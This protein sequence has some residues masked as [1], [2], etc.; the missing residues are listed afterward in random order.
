M[1]ASP[2]LLALT[3]ALALAI[4]VRAQPARPAPSTTASAAPQ[5]PGD[6]LFAQADFAAA[7][8]AYARAL[9]ANSA[10]VPAHVGLARIA[11][12]HNDLDV[13]ETHARAIV[14]AD[15]A[16][17]RGP[18]LLAAVAQ[19]RAGGSDYR[20]EFAGSETAVPFLRVDPVPELTAMV[21]GRP[22]RLLLDTG[23]TGLDLGGAF[24]TSIGLATHAAGEGVFAGGRRAEVRVGHVDVLQL[25]AAT[26]RSLPV[27]VLDGLP[28][29]LDGVLGTNV[30]YQF[31]ST[32]DY[33]GARLTLRPKS[34][35]D[36]F[37]KAAVARNDAIVPMLLVP[38]HFIF[39]RARVGHAPE[40]LFNID[41]G[42][43]GI[44]VQLTKA[45]LDAAGI[46]PDASRGQSFGGGGGQS[47]VLPFVADVALGTK[48]IR[49]T[50][51]VYFPDGDQYGIFPFAVAGTI[52]HEFFKHGA[53]TFDF[54]AMKLIYSTV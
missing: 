4:P 3:V 7:S 19:R 30:L 17:P 13:A 33:T 41:T 32:I 9:A 37:E 25:G 29:G 44:G 54:A 22:A 43:G 35:S 6:V 36:A 16:N 11:L 2:A 31:L 39:A 18:G 45:S 26:I 28:P 53:L 1:R 5:E 14:Q 42:G 47:R 46:T 8:S 20:V 23:G 10:D 27:S 38:D 40:A 49:A 24:A 15:P 50:P 48:T 12:Y 34:D 51:G 52:S 21:N